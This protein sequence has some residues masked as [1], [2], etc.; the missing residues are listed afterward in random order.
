VIARG[1]RPRLALWQAL[2]AL[3]L[4]V[5]VLAPFAWIA[6]V[7]LTPPRELFG[8]GMR[9]LP[10][11]PTL[12]NYANV[13]RF[14]SFNRAFVNSALVAAATTVVA[15]ALS[16]SA[17]YAFARYRFRG[18]TLLLVALLLIY[19]LPGILLLVPLLVI[20]R[21]TGL[22]N[23]Y[24]GLVLAESTHAIPFAVWLLT[25]YF[26]SLPRDL[27]DAALIDG[28]SRV[29][30]MLRVTLPLAVPGIVAAGLFVFIASWNNFLFAFMFTSGESVR[31]LPVLLRQ[32]AFS[33]ATIDTGMMM[34]GTIMTALP[35]ALAFL[36]FQRY[37]VGGLSAG[38]VKG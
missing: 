7:S 17:G 19:M 13:F 3:A 25:N 11:S 5:F 30:A 1:A 37:L 15:I 20:L 32:F 23:T 26:A 18:R 2:A 21:T 8:Q 35:V 14:V 31:T 9:Y 33:E 24:A 38:A 6:V 4:L 16:V 34:S 22:L 36:F 29:G 28:C 27:E 12:E 10:T